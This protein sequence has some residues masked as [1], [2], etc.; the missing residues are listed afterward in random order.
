MRGLLVKDF[1]LA[2]KQMR[3]FLVLLVFFA[4]ISPALMTGDG[5]TFVVYWLTFV[6][7]FFV[8]TTISYDEAD[9]SVSFLLTLPVSRRQYAL[10]KYVFLLVATGVAWL[11][12][13]CAD[14][15]SALRSPGSI[16][17]MV[18]IDWLALPFCWSFV[19]LTIP[20]M[21]KF[22]SERGRLAM[23]AVLAVL[24]SFG[25]LL[26]Q[27]T[28]LFGMWDHADTFTIDI[29]VTA[30]ALFILAVSALISV[31]IMEKKDF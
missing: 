29:Q 2:L 11:I 9:N 19:A 25:Y 23:L 26:S 21:L 15:I 3:F 14:V 18:E 13:L 12:G 20:F 8:I 28:D 1:R 6:C 31:R 22:G 16:E 5:G 27:N 24:A 10:E 4:F 30:T 7:S 17:M